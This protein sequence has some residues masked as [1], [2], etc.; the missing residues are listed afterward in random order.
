M[1]NDLASLAS[2]RPEGRRRLLRTLL[3]LLVG[4]GMV[5]MVVFA[6]APRPGPQRVHLKVK[7]VNGV[8]VRTRKAMPKPR[9]QPIVIVLR[10]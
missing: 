4:H 7:V 6:T 1:S 2:D 5:C 8:T 10:K 9:A 3:L